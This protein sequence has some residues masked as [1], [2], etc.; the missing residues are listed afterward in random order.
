MNVKAG[1]FAKIV[2]PSMQ[3][4]LVEVVYQ[5]CNGLNPTPLGDIL[6]RNTSG[7]AYWIV[8]SLHG[9]IRSPTSLGSFTDSTYACVKDK[10]LKRIDP[11]AEPVDVEEEAEA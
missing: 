9:P 1:D 2:H 3:G 5:A 4:W 7:D 11:E 10:W 6:L 8:K